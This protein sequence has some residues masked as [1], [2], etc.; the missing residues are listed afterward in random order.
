M[1]RT[2]EHDRHAR[3]VAANERAIAVDDAVIDPGV[4]VT[5][6]ILHRETIEIDAADISADGIDKSVPA[7][8]RLEQV[9]SRH[10]DLVLRRAL[11][12]RKE[13]GGRILEI[14]L[15]GAQESRLRAPG[16]STAE[17]FCRSPCL[18]S[19]ATRTPRIT[20]GRVQ[21]AAAESSVKPDESIT[22]Q[23]RPPS[24]GRASMRQTIDREPGKAAGRRQR[25]PRRRRQSRLRHHRPAS[26]AAS[27]AAVINTPPAPDKARAAARP[28]R[29]RRGR[30]RRALRQD[31]RRSIC[32]RR[33]GRASR[34]SSAPDAAGTNAPTR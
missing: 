24:R 12:A 20:I 32:L 5:I 18:V 7:A 30:G 15:L 26:C 22:V 29:K 34:P 14:V 3:A 13:S 23:A 6:K 27:T 2:V 19:S 21:P 10:V 28:G 31:R 16:V 8:S 9:R 25:R 4:V 11:R 33:H 17:R 1:H